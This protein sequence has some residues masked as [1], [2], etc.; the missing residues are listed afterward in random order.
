MHHKNFGNFYTREVYVIPIPIGFILIPI[1]IPIMSRMAIPIPMGFPWEWDSHGVSHSHAHLYPTLSAMS[2]GVRRLHGSRRLPC[3]RARQQPRW[4]AGLFLQ[5]PTPS[6][7][8]R[9]PCTTRWRWHG[10]LQVQRLDAYHAD[11]GGAHLLGMDRPPVCIHRWSYTCRPICMFVS[12]ADWHSARWAWNGYQ[13]GLGSIP[14]P[15][16]MNCFTITGVHA[17]RLISR[18][19]KRVWRCPL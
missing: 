9:R 12:V 6:T 19:G 13:P 18:T 5:L 10:V 11:P 4:M 17:L 14:R 7:T 1:P 2:G 3:G 16:R 8:S 15:G